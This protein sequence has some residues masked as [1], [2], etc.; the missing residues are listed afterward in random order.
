MRFARIVLSLALVLNLN[1]HAQEAA[2]P[3]PPAVAA[4]S[5]YLM[6]PASGA[7]LAESA[8]DERLPPA[9]LTKLMTGYAIFKA[10]ADARITLEDQVRVS[11]R[12]W[13]MPGSRTFI[14]VN[15]EV[16][17]EDLLR[18]MIIQSGNDAAVALAEHVSG[19]V[20][21]FVELMNEH[22]GL[23][24]MTDTAFRN[25]TGLP[26]R[27]HYSTARDF[28]ILAKAIIDEFPQYYALYREREFTY[29][30]IRQ[31]NRNAL[32]WRDESVDGMKTGH[33]NAAGY[34]LVSS[35]E[36]SG[37]RLIAVVLGM[38]S[39]GARTAAS[40]ALLNYGFEHYETHKLF[41]R[42]EAVTEAR[43]WKG[44]PQIAPLG[45]PDDLYV[46]IPRGRFGDLGAT[47]EV[48]AELIAPIDEA[49]QVGEV[50]VAFQGERL[51]VLPLVSLQPVPEAGL[52]TRI[53]D[54]FMHWLEQP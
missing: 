40:A 30:G 1:V 33:T 50:R 45:I 14:E 3:P 25:P 26:A 51:A 20:E 36:R 52:W 42:N 54:G 17:V 44:E 15:T 19:S 13:R 46:T 23:L 43:V 34:C 7:V 53:S 28:A 4:K 10:L 11:E 29:N 18:G 27:D 31:H 2:I 41:T 8:A 16:G 24:G 12:A 32:L 6:D 37:M 5:F 21:A 47:M 48:Q 22:A 35:A 38:Q 39:P 49:A 9:S